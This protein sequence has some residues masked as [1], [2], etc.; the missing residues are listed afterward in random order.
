MEDMEG[1][2]RGYNP[3]AEKSRCFYGTAAKKFTV[4]GSRFTVAEP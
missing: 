3:P 4:H 2:V 1:V